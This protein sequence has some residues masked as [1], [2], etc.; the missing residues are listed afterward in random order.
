[1]LCDSPERVI[2]NLK[3]DGYFVI[4]FLLKTLAMN[5]NSGVFA[6]FRQLKADGITCMFGNPG[7]SEALRVEAPGRVAPAI[8]EALKDDHPFLTDLML[9]SAI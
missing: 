7:S 2:A 9:D 6:F 3:E 5:K 1:M 8:E 4:H